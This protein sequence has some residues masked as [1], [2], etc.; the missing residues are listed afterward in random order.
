LP[1]VVRTRVGYA[2]GTRQNPTYH[3]LGD[4]TETIQ[5]DYDPS[6][7][8]YPELLDAFWT[9]HDPTHRSWS[10]QYASIIFVHNEEQIRLAEVSK[11]RITMDRG[12]TVY[13]EIVP[14]NG[15]TLAENYHQKHGLQQ[16]PEFQDELKQIYTSPAE[17]VASTAVAR[18]NG[19]LGGEGSYE[20][21]LKE[22]EGFGLSSARQEEL[23]RLVHQHKGRQACPMPDKRTIKTT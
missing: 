2:G 10:R 20:V 12:S 9:G 8:T 19:Y 17:F 16:F 22:K 23:L 15:F 5:I 18:V 6:K 14:Y 13:T 3:D 11:A 4:H 21:L 7:I 1:G